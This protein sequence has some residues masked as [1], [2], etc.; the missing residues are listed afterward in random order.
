[1]N[2][3]PSTLSNEFVR[4]QPLVE[5]D[6]ER[7]HEVA[8]DPLI[9]EQHPNPDRYKRKTFQIFFE[10]AMKSGSSFLVFDSQ[11]NQLIGSSRYYGHDETTST[12]NIG[13]TFLARS[14][15]GTNH[16]RALKTVMLN[17]AFE[18]VDNVIF[19]IGAE[20][21][22]SQK[23]IGKL[24]AIKIGE[25]EMPYYGEQTKLNFVHQIQRENWIS[26]LFFRVI[27]P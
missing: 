17:Y 10:G 27:I 7:L 16:N 11:T 13:Y 21:I 22:R 12:V 20:N 14:H 1:M 24:G 25:L 6:F 8:S 26:E 2:L 3:Q 5:S 15:W 19:H 23:A 4:L 18:F 9:W